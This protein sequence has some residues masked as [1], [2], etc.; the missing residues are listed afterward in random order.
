MDTDRDI[1]I[2]IE[3]DGKRIIRI[4]KRIK[5]NR[6]KACYQNILA[7]AKR[8]DKDITIE[9]IKVA[10]ENLIQIKRSVI[11]NINQ[12]KT[13]M[14]SFKFVGEDNLETVNNS[15][16]LEV[17]TED[18][19]NLNSLEH[20]INNKLYETLVNKIQD[21]DKNTTC[22]LK[23]NMKSIKVVSPE[24]ENEVNNKCNENIANV[25]IDQIEF[26]KSELKS[27]DSII[28][29]LISNRASVTPNNSETL[30][31]V[32]RDNNVN[33]SR[34]VDSNKLGESKQKH[35]SENRQE[36][37]LNKD[38]NSEWHDDDFQKIKAKATKELKPHLMRKQ[39]RNKNDR[40]YVYSFSGATTKQMEHYSKPPMDF[41]PDFIILHTGT[42]SLRGERTPEDLAEEI[43]DLATSL[44]SDENEIVISEIIARRDQLNE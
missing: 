25:L 4:I 21:E 34:N 15:E 23:A 38:R 17:N 27:K 7:F 12:D 37:S 41:N 36:I 5:Y 2:N 20:F 24:T 16:I 18:N 31:D 19:A 40:L 11:T 8:E 14:E 33:F 42:N 44:K 9:R 1:N 3:D 32:T 26:L 10:V 28:K 6:K 35:N 13:D 43:I 30:N 22:S 39:L 29:M